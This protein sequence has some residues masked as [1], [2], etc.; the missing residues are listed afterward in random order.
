MARAQMVRII[1]SRLSSS[2]LSRTTW[3]VAAEQGRN[4]LE[5]KG[6]RP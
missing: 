6:S 2:A 5:Q 3:G 1:P 4:C